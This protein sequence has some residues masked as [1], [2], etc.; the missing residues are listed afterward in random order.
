MPIMTGKPRSPL[1]RLL[2]PSTSSSS[3][4]FKPASLSSFEEQSELDDLDLIYEIT[5]D[6]ARYQATI[7]DNGTI[8]IMEFSDIIR[9]NIERI[10]NRITAT[11]SRN[12]VIAACL[13]FCVPHLFRDDRI[14]D[15][16]ITRKR[17]SMAGN[18]IPSEISSV[19]DQMINSFKIVVPAGTRHNAVIPRE[20]KN[21]TAGLAGEIGLPCSAL[22]TI[23][24]M[25]VLIRQPDCNKGDVRK[26]SHIV[27]NFWLS[28][29]ARCRA[30]QALLDTYQL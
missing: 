20:Y 26:M 2:N 17:Y 12:V 8:P 1:L 15:I 7:T 29:T 22:S 27:D 13:R 4:T 6:P 5:D 16:I 9:I 3:S 19:L 11:P 25:M 24:I 30:S 23:C 28:I 14:K 21:M 10:R 18:D